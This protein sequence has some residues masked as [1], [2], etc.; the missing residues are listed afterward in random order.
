MKANEGEDFMNIKTGIDI[1]E[2]NRIKENIEKFG[3]KFLNRVFTEK[4]IEYCESK[5]VQKFQSYSGRFAAKEAIFK[6]LSDNIDNKFEIEWKDIEIVNDK[7][8]RPHAHLNGKLA[9]FN[10]KIDV[11]ISHIQ[12][13]AISNA[14]AMFE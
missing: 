11:S 5:K 12:N 13:M 9:N 4:E 1:I 3:D 6:A 7:N 14:I 8:G 10:C 2:V